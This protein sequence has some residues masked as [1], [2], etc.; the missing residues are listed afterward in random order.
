MTLAIILAV[1][2]LFLVFFRIP[3]WFTFIKKEE[4]Q[5]RVSIFKLIRLVIPKEKASIK[6]EVKVKDKA[7]KKTKKKKE[8]R[9]L[10]FGVLFK[11][12]L[13]GSFLKKLSLAVA[14]FLKRLLFSLRLKIFRGRVIYG[15]GDPAQTGIMLGRYYALKYSLP[16]S[17]EALVVETDFLKK[18]FDLEVRGR[19]T[20]HPG[21]I[22]LA[23]LLLLVEWP[24]WKT[25]SLIRKIR[26]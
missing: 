23:L 1:L 3:V 18:R 20:I 4:V 11:G 16:F 6:A 15:A 22:L 7:E 19:V 8:S 5:V 26:K 14:R 25:V 24:L 2:A 17:T 10:D 21:R 12:L 9:K 13:D